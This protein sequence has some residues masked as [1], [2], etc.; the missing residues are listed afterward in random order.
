MATVPTT[1]PRFLL[2]Q[3]TWSTRASQHAAFG[4]NAPLRW[5]RVLPA[6]SEP[7]GC[8]R[9]STVNRPH[10]LSHQSRPRRLVC[11]GGPKI[12]P[13]LRRE[14]SATAAR[15]R[16]HHFDTLKFVQRLK[17]EGFTEEQAVAMMRVLSDVIEERYAFVLDTSLAL[18]EVYRPVASRTSRALWCSAKTRRRRHTHRRWTSPNCGRSS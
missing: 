13:A 12:S 11:H 8:I 5:R 9:Y 2:P 4:S 7:T 15:A 10:R 6:S 3:L 18:A 1:I 17:H 16:D 14:F